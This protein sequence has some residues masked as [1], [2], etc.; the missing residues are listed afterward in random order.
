MTL[1]SGDFAIIA[2]YFLISIGLGLSLSRRGGASLS[3]FFLSGRS[4]P[5]WLVGTGMVATTFAADT[6]LWVA[7]KVGNYGISGNWLWWSSAA[8]GM[9]TL[10]FFARLWRRAG[11]M[12]DLEFIE[13]RYSGRLAAFLRGFKAV[14]FGVFANLLVMGWVNLAM[15]K[16]FSV[17]FPEQNAMW[18]TTA[19]AL[20][21]LAYVA[22][23]G[24]WG[25]VIAD[26]FQFLIAMGGC[27]LLAWFALQ[28]P[29]VAAAGGLEGALAPSMFDFFP[30][31]SAAA[32]DGD[33]LEKIALSAFLAYM[34]IQWWASW[35]PGAEPGG[36]GYI[37][38]RI[39]SAKDEKNGVLATLWFLIAHFCVRSWPWIIAALAAVVIYPE[40]KGD[41]R[42]SGYVQLIRDTLPSPYRGLLIAAFMGAYM[43]TLA[44]H[45]NWGSSYVINDFYRRFVRG[46]KSDAHYVLIGRL[47]T[48]ALTALS[49]FV[50][51]Y[52]Y[53]SIRGAWD[54][55][56]SVT[57]G[58][59]FILILRWYW[60]RINAAAE[61]AS[62]I[63][64]LVIGGILALGPHVIEGFPVFAAPQN[65]FVIVPFSI[66][67]TVIVMY[68]FP[69]EDRSTLEAFF[70][71]VRPGGPGWAPYVA[72][73]AGQ[74]AP[75]RLRYL[76][77]GW[78]SG[79]LL[80][81]STLF[82]FGAL[83]FQR[84][85]ES[86]VWFALAL[87]GAGGCWYALQRDFAD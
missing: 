60:W 49:L 18:L 12:T 66:L 28:H 1:G 69:A 37:A 9:L 52:V 11:V 81:Y 78:I 32:L 40:L 46:A 20:I 48:L 30:D 59:G 39:M 8:G 7:G 73:G 45:L 57:G 47:S 31:F 5:W 85:S 4:T 80:I 15:A 82:L 16:I 3:E 68:A 26:A 50:A 84:W 83:F 38:Q 71:R 70:R 35:Y 41:E 21:T 44:T 2:L 54:F 17:L 19:A 29:A 36:G 65:L 51:F 77:V 86:G 14:Y 33:G 13:L 56:L 72:A 67:A 25:V 87:V 10:F 27:I 58:M 24:L 64:P 74:P 63:A 43:S 53:D 62:M 79:V 76:F 61:L 23:S 22:T 6:P 75:S 55:I 34:L 42:E